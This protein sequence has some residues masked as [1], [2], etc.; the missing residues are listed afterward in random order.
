MRHV[1]GD[2]PPC[3][4]PGVVRRRVLHQCAFQGVGNADQAEPLAG[5]IVEHHI[6]CDTFD[7][8]SQQRPQAGSFGVQLGEHEPAGAL[9]AFPGVRSEVGTAVGPRPRQG[10]Q[11]FQI[12]GDGVMNAAQQRQFRGPR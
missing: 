5:Q 3:V 10:E 4:N 1:R 9:P 11:L 2:Q 8:A 7:L 6:V 12:A